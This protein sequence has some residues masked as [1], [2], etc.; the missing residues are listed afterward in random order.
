[1]AGVV[2][3]CNYTGNGCTHF[4]SSLL[5]KTCRQIQMHFFHQVFKQFDDKLDCEFIQELILKSV[6]AHLN[7]GDFVVLI[8]VSVH[9]S[10]ICYKYVVLSESV[11]NPY[12]SYFRCW[13]SLMQEEIEPFSF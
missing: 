13:E 4:D 7:Y 9:R 11:P 1:M 3:F 10:C 12:S 8:D 2:D 6:K 5:L